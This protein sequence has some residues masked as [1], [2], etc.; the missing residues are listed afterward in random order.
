[1]PSG[2]TSAAAARNVST[3]IS[4]C[5]M[6]RATPSTLGIGV[7]KEITHCPVEGETN[8]AVW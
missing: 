7:A 8:G 6:P 1:M 2:A 4:N 3:G 5:T